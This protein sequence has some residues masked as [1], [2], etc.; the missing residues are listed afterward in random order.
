M[1][2]R[3]LMISLFLSLVLEGCAGAINP[4]SSEFNCPKTAEGKCVS[5]SAA[6]E[7]SIRKGPSASS[8]GKDGPGTSSYERELMSKLAGLLKEPSAPMVSPASVLRVLFLPYPGD[9][10]ELY[11]YRYAY[12]FA[13]DPTWLLGDYLNA[14]FEGDPH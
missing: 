8:A 6:Y 3:Y 13:E 2:R 7:E 5:V 9:E 1:Q 11:L 4:Y 10:K 14:D 12:V